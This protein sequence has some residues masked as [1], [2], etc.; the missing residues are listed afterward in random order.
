M[1]YMTIPEAAILW[2]TVPQRVRRGC[3]THQ[4]SGAVRF[5][6]SW[7]IPENTSLPQ[8]VFDKNYGLGV[9]WETQYPIRL[10]AN[11]GV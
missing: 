10:R 2:H 8:D 5:G 7:L 3:E 11:N 1:Q 6:R 4:I 9:N